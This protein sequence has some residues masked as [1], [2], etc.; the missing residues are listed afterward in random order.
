MRHYLPMIQATS[1]KTHKPPGII[2]RVRQSIVSRSSSCREAG[3]LFVAY[4]YRSTCRLNAEISKMSSHS[5]NASV[6]PFAQ[7][8]IFVHTLKSYSC[9]GRKSL[10]V[11]HVACDRTYT[12]WA[13]LAFLS[14]ST[15]QQYIRLSVR[16]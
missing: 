7:L 1:D 15:C 10:S 3:G 6:L 12:F 4:I 11:T 8:K 16:R 13:Y 5:Y 14:E 9:H 2:E